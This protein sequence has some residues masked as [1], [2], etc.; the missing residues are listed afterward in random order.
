MG[1]FNFFKKSA[2]M[3][4]EKNIA[5]EEAE[6]EKKQGPEAKGLGLNSKMMDNEMKH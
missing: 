2:G 3:E 5:Y 4:A 1:T 6:E